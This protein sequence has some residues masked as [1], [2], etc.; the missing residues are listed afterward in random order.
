L[1]DNPLKV[2][3]HDFAVASRDNAYGQNAGSAAYERL[4]EHLALADLC[5]DIPVAPRVVP[6][7]ENPAVKDNADFARKIAGGINAF[8]FAVRFFS[9]AKAFYHLGKLG[10]AYAL[11]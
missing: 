10:I 2:R 4:R 3:E 5:D 1:H 11:E 6:D 8:T 9:R 7:D